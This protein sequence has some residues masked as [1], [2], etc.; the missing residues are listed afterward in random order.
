MRVMIEDK[1]GE[2]EEQELQDTESEHLSSRVTDNH[3]H[4]DSQID[5][6]LY[7]ES[8]KEMRTF[9]EGNNLEN[10]GSFNE[11]HQRSCSVVNFELN[12]HDTAPIVNVISDERILIIDDDPFN[13]TS[14]KILLKLTLKK[15]GHPEEIID[16]LVD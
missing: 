9:D 11:P 12:T 13:L 16:K 1:K 14:L 4:I 5:I 3:R 2:H 8:N 7:L 10:L 15:L 6:S